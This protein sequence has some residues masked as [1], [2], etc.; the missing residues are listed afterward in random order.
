MQKKFY[1]QEW[2]T[3]VVDPENLEKCKDFLQYV[4]LRLA[5][6]ITAIVFPTRGCIRND[7]CDV[8]D[9]LV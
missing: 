4:R 5:L 6:D 3:I 2:Q 7:T 8:C 9:L 1:L